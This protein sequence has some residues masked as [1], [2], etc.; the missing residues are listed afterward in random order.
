MTSNDIIIYMQIVPRL[1]DNFI[2]NNYKL[3][4]TINRLDRIFNGIVTISGTIPPKSNSIILHCKQ[5][6]IKSVILNGKTADYSFG[7]NDALIIPHPDMATSNHIIKIDFSGQITDSMHGIYPC[8]F[9]HDG[10]KKELIATQFE[11][12]HAREVFPCIDEPEAKAVFDVT[13]T[14]ETDVTVLGNMPI[15]NQK[16]EGN[17]LVTKFESTPIMSSYLLAW[18]IGELHKKTAHTKSGVEVNVWATPAQPNDNLDFGLDIATRSIDFYEEYFG[19]NYP[20]SKCDNVALPDFGSGAMENWGLITYREIALL[21]DPKTTSIASKHYIA[22]VISHELSH[23]WFGNLV[24]MKWWNDLWLNE[25]FASLI[26]YFAIDAI[27][28]DWNVW[29]DFASYE[30][31][32]ALHRDSLAGVQSVQTDVN[33]PDE[34]SSLF[35]GAIVYAKGARLLKML[36]HYIGADAFRIGISKY[37]KIYA[38]KSTIDSDLWGVFGDISGKDISQFMNS[39]ISQPGFPVLHVSRNGNQLLLTQNRLTSHPENTSNSLWPIT[40]NSNYSEMPEIFDCQSMTIDV[41]E[42]E[43]IRFNIGNDAH[44]ITHYDTI[45]LDQLISQIKSNELSPLDRLQLLNEQ[46]ILANAGIISN[47]ELIPLINAYKNESTEAVWDIISQTIGGLKKFVETDADTEIK[48]RAL[49]S[50]LA[51]NQYE[52]LGWTPKSNEPDTNTKLRGTII[53]LMLY[54][55]NP[56]VIDIA[57]NKFY[58]CFSTESDPENLNELS[59]LNPELRALIISATVRHKPSKNTI[60]SLIKIYKSTSSSELKQDI[61]IGLT[62]SRDQNVISQILNIITDTSI[63]RTQDTARWIAYLIRNKFARDQIWLWLRD[64]WEWI[65]VTFAGDKSY[66]DYPRYV[67]MALTTKKQL[68]EYREFFEPKMSDPALKRVIEMGINEI[69]DRVNLIERDGPVVRKTLNNL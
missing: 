7:D 51:I 63:I 65:D 17:C 68:D 49:S 35:D 8:Y 25:S 24:T 23:Q 2:P 11:S 53:G 42:F 45:L 38:Y 58:S 64:N 56:E 61:N 44:F 10:V 36:Q 47:A 50:S 59:G 67:A 37:F 6:D 66:D 33:H 27:E 3:T 19:I 40:L 4:I 15:E 55:E 57:V 21:A 31:I 16:T 28:P 46:S 34:I 29:L 1:I 60:N 22:A 69:S 20:L 62:S 9:D 30:T 18:V 13:L 14:T 52:I 12:H 5:L 41:N 48:L 54:S 32:S 26:E 43:P 39:W